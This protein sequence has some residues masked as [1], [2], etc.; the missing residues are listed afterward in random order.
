MSKSH[1]VVH[2]C[3]VDFWIARVDVLVIAAPRILPVKDLAFGPQ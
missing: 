3:A 1:V 2:N